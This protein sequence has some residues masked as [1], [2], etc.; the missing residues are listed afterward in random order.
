MKLIIEIDKFDND[1]LSE[2]DGTPDWIAVA[3]MIEHQV[4]TPLHDGYGI[5]YVS[6]GALRDY[7]GNLVGSVKLTRS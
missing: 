5:D 6:G 1:A 3:D 4:T 2:E 7:N